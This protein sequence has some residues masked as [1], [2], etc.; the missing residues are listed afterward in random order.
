MLLPKFEGYSEVEGAAKRIPRGRLAAAAT[1]KLKIAASTRVRIVFGPIVKEY[2]EHRITYYHVEVVDARADEQK[3]TWVVTH[4]DLVPS[5][6]DIASRVRPTDDLPINPLLSAGADFLSAEN[7]A[8][9]RAFESTRGRG[10]AGFITTMNFA[11]MAQQIWETS[12]YSSRAPKLMK[13]NISFAPVHDIAPGI[14]HTGFNR[15]PLYPVGDVA[16][17]IAGDVYDDEGGEEKFKKS[18][19]KASSG[20]GRKSN[21]PFVR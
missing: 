7:N 20:F 18:H 16:G 21:N 12:A 19:E 6:R 4:S 17:A 14:D 3:G 2:G 5:L 11:E 15:A 1:R 10:L 8:V 9:V 13:V